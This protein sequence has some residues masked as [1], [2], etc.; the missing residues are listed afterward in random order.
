MVLIIFSNLPM[1]YLVLKTIL[2][3]AVT[4]FACPHCQSRIKDNNLFLTGLTQEGIAIAVD[5]PSCHRR[6]DIQA[7]LK[8]F[9]G[10]P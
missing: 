10:V 5:C 3:N 4:T 7:A 6:T 9:P 2:A 1:N 8:F